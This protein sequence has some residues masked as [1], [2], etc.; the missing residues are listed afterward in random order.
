GEDVP[1]L[2]EAS[3][4]TLAA[5]AQAMDD[6]LNTSVALAAVYDLVCAVNSRLDELGT[7][8]ITTAEA[9]VALDTFH[10]IDRVFGLISTA[11]REKDGAV[12]EK[13]SQWVEE[14]LAE[15]ADARSARD[16][17]RADEIRQELA[18]RGVLVEDTPTG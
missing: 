6:D 3:A 8:S 13:F 7:L 4:M 9:E 17:S 5:F 14:R 1:S 18:A 11:A 2:H 10:R 15:R 12:D 16:F